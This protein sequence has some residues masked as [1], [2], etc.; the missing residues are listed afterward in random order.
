MRV[1]SASSKLNFSL[2]AYRRASSLRGHAAIL[3]RGVIK[4]RHDLVCNGDFGE[5]WLIVHR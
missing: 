3:E 4:R 1:A 2:S 5:F